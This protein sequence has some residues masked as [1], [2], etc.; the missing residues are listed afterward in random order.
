MRAFSKLSILSAFAFGFGFT[1][2][3]QAEPDAYACFRSDEAVRS[4]FFQFGQVVTV[5]DGTSVDQDTQRIQLGVNSIA[6]V[7][8]KR[9]GDSSTLTLEVGGSRQAW[10]LP[11]GERLYLVRCLAARLNGDERADLVVELSARGNGLAA[12]LSTVVI[13]LSHENTYTAVA[14]ETY[15]FAPQNFVVIAP[16]LGVQWVQ[17]SFAQ[18]KGRDDKDHS[19]WLH[20][21]WRIMP[22]GVELN[23][24]FT[25]RILQYTRRPNQTETNLLSEMAKRTLIAEL[26][27]KS[28]RLTTLP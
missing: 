6:G 4:V 5:T 16:E 21:L 13:L 9:V 17:T 28:V 10:G 20:R 27:T 22:D 14:V 26:P 1:S 15:Q 19:F 8:V 11:N 12:E 25:P 3:M 24:T 18:A 7:V 2:S 23:T